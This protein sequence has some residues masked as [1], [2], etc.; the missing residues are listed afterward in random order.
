[1]AEDQDKDQDQDQDKEENTQEENS[2]E[3]SEDAEGEPELKKTKG[4]RLILIISAILLIVIAV[5]AYF[6]FFNNSKKQEEA[7]PKEEAVIEEIDQEKMQR[8]FYQ[9]EEFI[10]NLSSANNKANFLKIIIVLHLFEPNDRVE[11]VKKEPILRD[12]LQVF[13]K[14][15]RSE[16]LKRP[17]QLMNLKEEIILRVNKILEPLKVQD[18]LFKEILI[19]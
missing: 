4:K 6:F 10:V 18:V 8:N 11:V 19:N 5:V 9:M 17:G 2:N 3:V 16:D 13:L 1:M 7:P 15:L 14:A 12:A